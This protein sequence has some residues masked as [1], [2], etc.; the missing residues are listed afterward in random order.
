MFVYK[1][2]SGYWHVRFNSNKFFQW[3]VGRSPR[4]SDGF[5]WVEEED[6]ERARN[7]TRSM[8]RQGFKRLG[9]A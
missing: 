2:E 9:N 3:P 7:A 5:G 6:L 4:L 8:E 1:L